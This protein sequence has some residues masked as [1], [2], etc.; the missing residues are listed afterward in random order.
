VQRDTWEVE[1]LA[2][3]TL[4]LYRSGEIAGFF[5][6]SSLHRDPDRTVEEELEVVKLLRKMGYDGYIH[7][8]LMPGTSR[9]LIEEAVQ[10]VDRVG[11]NLEAPTSDI[12]DE[13]CPDKGSFK[14][15]VIKR[16]Q[17]VAEAVSSLKNHVDVDTQLVLGALP[18]SDREYLDVT[19]WLYHDLGLKRVYYSAF[20]PIPGTP[21]EKSKPC[22]PQREYR[23]YQASFL[24][25]DYG[26]LP[27]ELYSLLTEDGFLPN[28]DP[29]LAY[30]KANKDMFPIDLNT[31]SKSEMIKVPGIGPV[32]AEKITRARSNLKISRYSDLEGVLGRTLARRVAPY[33]DLK[34]KRLRNLI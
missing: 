23:M 12:F 14:V 7:L 34:D 26:F 29:K 20:E 13:L 27:D 25:R 5:L 6:S 30:A 11:V 32:T 28:V 21:L 15:D 3:L 19:C 17:W 1:K 33:V 10:L 8:R 2:K 22:P 24:I 9:H 31:A 16:L 18:D 4:S